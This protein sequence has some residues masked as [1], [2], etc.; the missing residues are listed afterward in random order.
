MRKLNKSSKIA[1]EQKTF[2]TASAEFLRAIAKL[3]FLQGRLC[4]WFEIHLILKFFLVSCFLY[5]S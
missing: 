5:V 3:I 1:L 4:T 2:I